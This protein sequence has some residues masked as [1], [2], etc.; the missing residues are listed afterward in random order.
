MKRKLEFA[1]W[2]IEL[3]A[4]QLCLFISDIIIINYSLLN[5]PTKGLRSNRPILSLPTLAQTVQVILYV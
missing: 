1:V 4:S 3:A 2:A 5:F